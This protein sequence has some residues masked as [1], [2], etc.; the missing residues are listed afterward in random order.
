MTNSIRHFERIEDLQVKNEPDMARRKLSKANEFDKKFD[1][2]AE[3]RS[4]EPI[5]LDEIKC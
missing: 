3:R 2:V 4:E 1:K 5:P